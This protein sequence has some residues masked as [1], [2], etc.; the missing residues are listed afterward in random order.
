MRLCIVGIRPS[1]ISAYRCRKF[2]LTP[3]DRQGVS[4]AS[5]GRSGLQRADSAVIAAEPPLPL[6]ETFTV[7]RGSAQ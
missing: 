1:A 2:P 5:V 7:S 4:P 3:D 6:A